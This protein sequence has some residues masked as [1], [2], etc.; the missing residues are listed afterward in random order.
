MDGLMDD[1]L[2]GEFWVFCVWKGDR[3]RKVLMIFEKEKREEI[4]E[5]DSML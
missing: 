5:I 4:D 1:W 3:K 2:W